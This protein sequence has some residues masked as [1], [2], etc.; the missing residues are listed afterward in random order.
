[1]IRDMIAA[2]NLPDYQLEEVPGDM[3]RVTPRRLVEEAAR[4][5]GLRPETLEAARDLMPGWDVYALE[6]EWRGVWQVSGRPP[7]RSPDKAFLGWVKKR[8]PSAQ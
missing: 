1:M 4:G 5:P 3:L 2:D 8:N 6:A 7:L